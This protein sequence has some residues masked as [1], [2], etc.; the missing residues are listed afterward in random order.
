MNLRFADPL[1]LFLLVVPPAVA[2][3]LFV[4]RR[5]MRPRMRFSSLAL[6]GR[7]PR[8]IKALARPIPVALMLLAM[9]L[10]IVALARPQIPWKENKRKAEGI[11]IMMV[12]DT[13]ESMRA[14]DFKPNRLVKAKEVVIDFIK[15]RTDDMIG[16]VIFGKETFTL[17]PLTHDYA[18]L[19]TFVN[20]IDYDLVDGQATAIGMGLANGV[21]KIKDAPTKSKVII[22]MTDG[23]NNWGEIQPLTAAELARD[24]KIRVYTIGVGSKG[25]V[26]IPS[27]VMGGGRT[28][29][30]QMMSSIDTELLA[31]IAEMTGGKTFEASNNKALEDVC[32]QI[33]QL[34]K[35]KIET[36]ENNYYDELA[37][38]FL[39]PAMVLLALSMMLEL[40]WLRSFP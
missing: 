17:A 25:V 6:I 39:A 21:N 16:V 3:Y 38:Y 10:M 33:D 14:L 35:T 9:T 19:E 31:K 36:N 23:E 8:S 24:L 37:H 7:A 32:A 12:F 4:R 20:R 22:L 27:P 26:D 28:V 29:I 5:A 34:E 15:K 40:T 2:G 11:S 30:R 18:A 13:S 1:F